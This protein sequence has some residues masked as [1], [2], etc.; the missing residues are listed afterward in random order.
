[1]FFPKCYIFFKNIPK[2]AL[3]NISKS[4]QQMK[5]KNCCFTFRQLDLFCIFSTIC[6]YYKPWK[7]EQTNKIKLLPTADFM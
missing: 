4:K 1:M 6:L 2:L 5:E 7:S 3:F